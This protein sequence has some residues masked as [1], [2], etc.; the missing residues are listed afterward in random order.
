MTWRRSRH[1]PEPAP[2]HMTDRSERDERRAQPSTRGPTQSAATQWPNESIAWSGATQAQD[3]IFGPNRAER[4]GRRPSIYRQLGAVPALPPP[5]GS[6]LLVPRLDAV[7]PLAL[8]ARS[9]WQMSRC[10][11]HRSGFGTAAPAA[12]PAAPAPQ[13][14]RAI[15]SCRRRALRALPG[16]EWH[17]LGAAVRPGLASAGSRR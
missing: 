13:S 2:R 4:R 5:A 11:R 1:V 17:A 16:A 12:P 8:R 10:G 7:V 6:A 15:P 9:G 3:P 14:P